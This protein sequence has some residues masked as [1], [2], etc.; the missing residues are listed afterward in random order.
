MTTNHKD[1]GG[2]AFPVS[3]RSRVDET[4]GSYGHQDSNTT[5]QF[6][7]M[8]MLDFFA[9]HCL[10]QWFGTGSP[11]SRAKAAYAD[12]RAMLKARGEA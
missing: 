1:D 2:P 8:T 10:P 9:I 6:P 4:S 5:W 7:G 11:E 12:A 3:T